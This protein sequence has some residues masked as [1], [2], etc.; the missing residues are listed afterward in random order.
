MV[1]EA[2]ASACQSRDLTLPRLLCEPGRSLVAPAGV[3]LYSV[4]SRKTI[5]GIRTYVA[6]DGGMSDNPRPIT[7]QSLY[8]TCLADR[9]L[10]PAVETV[11][12][13]GK[14]CESG[15]VLLKGLPL[16]ATKPGDV[17]VVL[18][19]GAYNASMASNYNRIPRPAAVMV[20]EG[21]SELVQRRER[22]DE[23]LRYDVL[24]ERLR[25][26]G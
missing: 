22:P 26:V 2:V 16:P 9:P 6:V 8:T 25:S 17:L 11:N 10:A 14:H 7:Y 20:G 5:P 4:G 12:L 21:R 13:V 18:A 19:T 15:D 23:L 24:P 3:T 1:S